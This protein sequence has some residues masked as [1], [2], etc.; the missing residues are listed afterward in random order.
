M[1]QK[2]P[3]E[4]YDK[5]PPEYINYILKPLMVLMIKAIFYPKSWW[6]THKIKIIKAKFILMITLIIRIHNLIVIMALALI[7]N[8]HPLTFFTF[9][10]DNCVF[11]YNFGIYQSIVKTKCVFCLSR[12]TV[13]IKPIDHGF[14]DNPINRGT[15][16]SHEISTY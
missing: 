3:K 12:S 6:L 13:P 9:H 16:I 15:Y 1:L 11:F 14:L 5:W 7:N 10:I 8:W 2:V 4:S